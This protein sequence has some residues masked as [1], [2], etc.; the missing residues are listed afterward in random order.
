MTKNQ[1]SLL[2][3][4]CPDDSINHFNLALRSVTKDQT[5]KPDEAVLILDGDVDIKVIQIIESVFN[6][7]QIKNT[8]IRNNKQ[9]GL[10]YSLNRG[11][12]LCSKKWVARMDADDIALPN[13][14]YDQLNYLN[15]HPSV[16]VLGTSIREFGDHEKGRDKIAIT[17]FNQI[18]KTLKY[19]NPIN[20]PSTIFNRLKILD[21]GGYPEFKK[22]KIMLFG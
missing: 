19:R 20:H 2:M 9:M 4:V 22:I 21:V 15:S 8:I 1:F 17:G 5:K 13:R 3:C 11:L 16:A 7:T 10:A 12:K 14:F 6:E 18:R